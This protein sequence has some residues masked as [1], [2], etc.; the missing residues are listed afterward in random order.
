MHNTVFTNCTYST[1]LSSTERVASPND[2]TVA[3]PIKAGMNGNR[4]TTVM[5][6]MLMSSLVLTAMGIPLTADGNDVPQLQQEQ[7]QKQLSP[8]SDTPRFW[9]PQ[10]PTERLATISQLDQLP[11]SLSRLWNQLMAMTLLP[12]LSLLDRPPP[13]P[14][15][16]V[17]M[18]RDVLVEIA[19]RLDNMLAAQYLGPIIRLAF[20]DCIGGCDGCLNLAQ[21]DNRGMELP[22]AG[23]EAVYRKH[24]FGAAISRADFWAL[25]GQLAV[26]RALRNSKNPQNPSCLTPDCSSTPRDAVSAVLSTFRVGRVD[27][28]TSPVT[29]RVDNIP[30]ARVQDDTPFFAAEFGLTAEETVAL[31]GA[32]NL[33]LA[34]TKNSGYSGVFV[35]GQAGV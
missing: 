23:L 21:P 27:C 11:F 26:E 31:M 33:G 8:S 10:P 19:T 9:S 22:L 24:N 34:T 30:T 25:A 20:H 13:P 6:V 17:P 18:R 3:K 5:M 7:Q 32:H 14:P 15:P 1:V 35:T 2:R 16:P 4:V 12:S 29:G 28:P